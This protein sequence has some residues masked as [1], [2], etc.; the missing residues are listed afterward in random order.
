MK[1][2]VIGL[3][4]MGL[5]RIGN[6]R[7]QGRPMEIHAVDPRPE[8]G[9][10]A[11]GRFPV[12]VHPTLADALRIG[13]DAAL[14]CT[15]PL[16]HMPV[17]TVLV[18]EKVPFLV[19]ASVVDDGLAGIIEATRRSG[20]VALPSCTMRFHPA[21]S[22][23]RRLLVEERY[24]GEDLAGCAFNYHMGQYLP[25]WHPHE[26]VAAFYVG[27]RETSGSR[28]MVCFENVWLSWLFGPPTAVACLADKKT[29]I[30]ADI[31]DVFQ[32]LLRY[33]SGASGS[34]MIDVISRVPYR[35]LRIASESGIIEWSARENVLRC[36]SAG[37]K[38]WTDLT[39]VADEDYRGGNFSG[40]E[41]Y[42]REIAAFLAA[43]DGDADAFPYSF[44]EDR[45]I[46][47]LLRR[48][49]ASARDGVILPVS[50]ALIDE[51]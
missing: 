3:G 15:P 43:L 48:A 34:M 46:L 39:A 35:S 40:E 1:V 13:P 20:L 44:E 16:A 47:S 42:D 14:V 27:N 4:S 33:G 51:I 50:P 9:E 30:D 6:L 37:R 45:L 26:D 8:R 29:A 2:L 41:M 28:E 22:A 5:R 25:D 32:L 23:I 24:L 38:A 21:I 11:A 7:R 49:L 17:M 12:T 31:E 36:Y 18:G 19:E 10:R